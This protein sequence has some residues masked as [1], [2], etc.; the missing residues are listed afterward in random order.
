MPTLKPKRTLVFSSADAQRAL[1]AALADRCEL[2]RTSMSLEIEQIL[3]EALIPRDGGFAERP[4]MRIYYGMGTVQGELA[5]IFQANAAGIDWKARYDDERPLVELASSQ[6]VGLTLDLGKGRGGGMMPVYHARSC[7]DSVCDHLEHDI[8][9]LDLD[10]A[11]AARVDAEVARDLLVQLNDDSA[12]PEAKGF[13]DLVLRNWWSLGNYTYT[14][15]ALMDI[16][17][18]ASGWPET[19]ESREDFKAAVAA[20]SAGRGGSSA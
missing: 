9:S 12:R 8:D 6:S 18:M 14:F 19:A 13:F 17:D 2:H 16:V 7:W 4:V 1:E 11:R 15:R 20:V 3:I 10:E 5:G